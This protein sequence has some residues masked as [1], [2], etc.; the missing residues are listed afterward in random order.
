MKSFS[1]LALTLVLMLSLAACGNNDNTSSNKSSVSTNDS[2]STQDIQ[3][4]E[5]NLKQI[6][7]GDYSSLLGTWTEVAYSDNRFD[8]TGQQWHTG[9]KNPFPT[10]SVSTDRI[11]FNDSAM[12]MQGNTITDEAGSHLV[13]FFNDEDLYAELVDSDT[14]IFWSVT[15]Y[16][17][18]IANDFEPNNGVKIDNTKNLISIWYSGMQRQTVF[19]QTNTS[20]SVK[21]GMKNSN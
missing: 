11:D 12:V 8:G 10:L 6:Q 15:F 7:A 1:V 18:G 4:A 20:N 14:A 2:S 16:P 21:S 9:E 5:I 13:K 17:K 3:G 19:A